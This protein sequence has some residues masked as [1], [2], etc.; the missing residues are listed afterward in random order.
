MLW[1]D[2]IHFILLTTSAQANT[3]DKYWTFYQQHG[4]KPFPADHLKKAVAEIEEMCNI[5]RHEGVT[6][7]RPEPIDW[8]LVYKTPDFTSSGKKACVK[9]YIYIPS[10]KHVINTCCQVICVLVCVPDQSNNCYTNYKTNKIFSKEQYSWIAIFNR[11]SYIDPFAG[12]YAAMPRDI[13]LVVGNE[14]IEAPMAWR[15]RFFEY[16]AYRPLIKEYFRKG[17][18]WTTAPKPTMSDELYDQVK[19]ST[20][21][22]KCQW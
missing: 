17:A 18:K 3:Y 12:M 20:T 2:C 7:R 14:I 5:L 1:P 4:G 9:T 21:R 16:R 19:S 13:L 22:L 6:V 11:S 8:S 10:I 15:S